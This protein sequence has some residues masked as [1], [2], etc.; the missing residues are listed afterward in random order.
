MRANGRRRRRTEEI[1][2]SGPYAQYT[3]KA[4]RERECDRVVVEKKRER[5]LLNC[6]S[7]RTLPSIYV[8]LAN[9]FLLLWQ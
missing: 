1:P 4:K 7:A 8:L 6:A 3:Q 5:E 9:V 2:P